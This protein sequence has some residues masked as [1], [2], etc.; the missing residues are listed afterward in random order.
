MQVTGASWLDFIG[1]AMAFT[2]LE[3]AITCS[4]VTSGRG[5]R[6]DGGSLLIIGSVRSSDLLASA[7]LYSSRLTALSL[8][9]HALLR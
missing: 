4:G 2:R 7:S 3:T 8:L 5:Q 1:L 6:S 9:R